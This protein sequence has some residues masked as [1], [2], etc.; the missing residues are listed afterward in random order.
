MKLNIKLGFLFVKKQR[1]QKT[2]LQLQ[3][4]ENKEKRKKV[5]QI[6]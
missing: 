6:R 2:K 5:Q 3:H 4:I 1:L